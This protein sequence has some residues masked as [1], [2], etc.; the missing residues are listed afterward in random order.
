MKRKPIKVVLHTKN[1]DVK[2][3][4]KISSEFYAI[5]AQ[6]LLDNSSLSIN[7]KYDLISD[8]GKVLKIWNSL[9][10]DCH[11]WGDSL[12]FLCHHLLTVCLSTL[13]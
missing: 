8:L 4:Q 12:P 9:M 13:R 1:A 3:I 7:D 6:T 2:Y 10:V 11:I 5:S